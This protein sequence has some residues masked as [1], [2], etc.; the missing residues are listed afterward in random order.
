[1]PY[2]SKTTSTVDIKVA[3][4]AGAVL[5]RYIEGL[6]G[7]PESERA[8]SARTFAQGLTDEQLVRLGTSHL[9][10]GSDAS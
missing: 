6:S 7:H 3:Q 10:T 9:A 2:V 5:S 1:M 8:S 4:E